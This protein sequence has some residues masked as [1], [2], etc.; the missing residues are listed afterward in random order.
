MI[1]LSIHIYLSE[2][3]RT[4]FKTKTKIPEIDQRCHHV[5]RDLK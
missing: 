5:D 3:S 1:N 4:Y 2:H